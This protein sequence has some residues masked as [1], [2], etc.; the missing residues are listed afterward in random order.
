MQIEQARELIKIAAEFLAAQEPT[1]KN[2]RLEQIEELDKGRW[3]IILSYPDAT[4]GFAVITNP[5]AGRIYKEVWV[6]E[7]AKEVTSVRMFKG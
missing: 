1:A 6:N 5:S 7:K 2:I 4:A 3:Q